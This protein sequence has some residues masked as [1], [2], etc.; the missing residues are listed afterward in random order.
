MNLKQQREAALQAAREIAERVKS[1]GRG[2]TPEE[3]QQ[4]DAHLAKAD[5]LNTQI[6]AADQA[7]AIMAKLGS[8]GDPGEKSG[9]A[10]AE[11]PTLGEHF[12]K[13]VGHEGLQRVKTHSGATV[14]APEWR[15]KANNDTQATP[16]ALAPWLTTYDR[17]IVRAFR[18]PVVSDLFGQGTLGAN[19]NA[20][21][22]LVEGSVEGALTTVAEGGSK[23]QFHIT[24]P[25]Q[26]SDALKKIAGFLKFTDEMVE[27]ADFWVSEINQRGLYLLALVEEAQLLTGSG[28]G[29]NIEGL[30]ERSGVQTETAQ[31]AEDNADALFRAMTKIQTATGLTADGVVI[32]PA[33]YQ[34][35]RLAKDA[36]KQ[37]YGGGFFQG[38]YGSGGVEWQPPIWGLRTVVSAAVPAGTAVVGA[39]EAGA[40][41]YRKG[42]VRV[43]STNS[44]STDFTSNLITTRIEER[45]ALAVRYPAAFVE[46]TLA[47]A[48]SGSGSGSAA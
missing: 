23:P 42:G 37:Y 16:S 19:S 12:V 5:E 27:D 41:V 18:R 24:D 38:Q 15:A 13:H 6:K 4:V 40:T 35:L 32:N 39:F 26:K 22:Y 25:T 31:D 9:D 48:A 10:D 29:A 34:A 8:F 30:L 44:H 14:A 46:V 7:D 47:A 11:A 33:D 20:V 2:F 43:E 28:A 45:V 36:N 1:E 17:T 21:T 3:Q